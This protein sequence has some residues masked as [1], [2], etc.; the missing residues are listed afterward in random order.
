MRASCVKQLLQLVHRQVSG[1]SLGALGDGD[2][3]DRI[4]LN[5]LAVQ[6]VVP[7]APQ[8]IDVTTNRV[9][10]HPVSPHLHHP[11][12]HDLRGDLG[13]VLPTPGFLQKREQL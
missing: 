1:E 6:Q 13:N 11:F 3:S 8:R 2:A 9:S 4:V 5:S 7:E 12:T 10:P